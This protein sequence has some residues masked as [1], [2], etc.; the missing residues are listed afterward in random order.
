MSIVSNVQLQGNAKDTITK[1]T[2]ALREGDSMFYSDITD[3]T[4]VS[5]SISGMVVL[6]RCAIIDEKPSDDL[7]YSLSK[8]ALKEALKEDPEMPQLTDCRITRCK[9]PKALYKE[10][11][12]ID[13]KHISGFWMCRCKKK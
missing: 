11:V 10:C 7:V 3:I 12:Y 9:L 2:L 4:I 6:N 13:K 5:G 8:E 1:S